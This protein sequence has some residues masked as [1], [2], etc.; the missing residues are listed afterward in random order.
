MTLS[1]SIL[2]GTPDITVSLGRLL[3]VGDMAEAWYTT[4]KGWEPRPRLCICTKPLLWVNPGGKITEVQPSQPLDADNMAGIGFAFIR[5]CRID[6][7]YT[8]REQLKVDIGQGI[9]ERF[10]RR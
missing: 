8:S 5:H 9:F 6:Y 1:P 3:R 7:S 4:E 10:F 2:S